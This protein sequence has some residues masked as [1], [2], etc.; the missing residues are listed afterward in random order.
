MA[1]GLTGSSEAIGSALNG[2]LG[3]KE[4]YQ[5]P[6][7]LMSALLDDTRRDNLLAIVSEMMDDGQT[8]PLRDYFQETSSN[9]DA[10]MQDYTPD[11]LCRLVSSILPETGSLLDICAGTGSLSAIQSQGGTHVQC[12]ELSTRALPVLLMNLAMRN[13]SATVLNRDVVQERT[14]AAFRLIPG[15]RFSSIEPCEPPEWRHFGAIVSNPPYSLKWD[16]DGSSAR[17][18]GWDIPPKSKA[19]YLFVLDAVSRLED[20]GTAVFILPHG[21]LFRGASEGKIRR[22]LVEDG[23]LHTVIGL[24]DRLFMHTGI[25]VCLFVLKRQRN[26][27]VLFVDA[28]KRFDRRGSVN[29]IS[30]RHISD[31][32]D[33]YN[34]RDDVE[35]FAHLASIDEIREND[36]NLNIPRYVDT[37]EPEPVPELM[38][39][40]GELMDIQREAGEIERRLAKTLRTL[41]GSVGGRDYQGQMRGFLDFLEGERP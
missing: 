38:Q 40:V 22:K 10:M 11:C 39:T 29:V 9:R 35:K 2:F 32:T 8:D 18:F 12:E 13:A 26:D 16:G 37:F 7:A 41:T 15:E 25:P 28:S 14:D 5:L 20:G 33:A 3:I 24:P 23:L 19:D 4:S 31:I 27:G 17:L 34:S 1:K 36:Y 6:D 30:K 21:V